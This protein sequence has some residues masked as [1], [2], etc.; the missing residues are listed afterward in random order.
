MRFVHPRIPTPIVSS[1][2]LRKVIEPAQFPLRL[3][4]QC[5]RELDRIFPLHLYQIELALRDISGG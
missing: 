2:K 3:Q 1:L 5:Y 4:H